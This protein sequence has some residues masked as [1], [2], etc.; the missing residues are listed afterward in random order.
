MVVTK[1]PPTVVTKTKNK[2]H[3]VTLYKHVMLLCMLAKDLCMGKEGF[4][5]TVGQMLALQFTHN[6]LI[7]N[8]LTKLQKLL[9][10]IQPWYQQLG[11]VKRVQTSNVKVVNKKEVKLGMPKKDTETSC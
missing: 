11:W 7:S 6:I 9:T 1:I 5:L 4:V 8:L 10:K 3:Q 2:M